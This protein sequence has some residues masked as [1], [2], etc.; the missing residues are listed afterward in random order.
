MHAAPESPYKW[1]EEDNMGFLIPLFRS[2]TVEGTNYPRQ[3][4][5]NAYIPNGYID[6]VTSSQV[7][8]RSILHGENILSFQS[9]YCV[10]ADRQDDLDYLNYKISKDGSVLLEYL[11]KRYPSRNHI[12]LMIYF[13]AKW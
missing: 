4:Y 3:Q 5:P 13:Y 8:E 1:F 11:R 10:E 6:I 9:P 12:V 2:V 7:L